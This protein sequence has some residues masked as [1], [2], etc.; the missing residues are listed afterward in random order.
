MA[1]K[2]KTKSSGASARSKKARRVVKKP[3]TVRQQRE[4]A[5]VAKP[6]TRKVRQTASKA[7]TPL[8]AIG[9]AIGKIFRPFRFV[10]RPFQTRPMR[11]IGRILAKIFLINYIR[12]SWRELRQV[13]WPS[14][15]ETTKLSIA[16][17]VFAIALSLVIAALDF[18]LDKVFRQILT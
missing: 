5:S 3:E 1:E 7:G 4:K 17:F 9:R 11:F 16:V 10:L 14:R 2:S 15:R 13:E 8:K 12:D 18:V 6:K